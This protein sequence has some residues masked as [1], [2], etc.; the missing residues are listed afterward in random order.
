MDRKVIDKPR[1]V[2]A[3]YDRKTG[4]V[5][6]DLSSRLT[7]SFSR[8]DAEGLEGATPAGLETIEISPSGLGIHFPKLDADLYV[9][10]LLE[11]S[12][13]SKRWMAARLNREI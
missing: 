2:A 10:A 6:I 9:P 12:L 1:A 8:R 13:G 4:R 3:R 5:V 11:G 7:V